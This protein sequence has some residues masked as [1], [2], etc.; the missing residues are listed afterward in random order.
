MLMVGH[1][2]EPLCLSRRDT[3]FIAAVPSHGAILALSLACHHLAL[4]INQCGAVAGA[5]CEGHD[6]DG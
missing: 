5:A 3:F 1:L 4:S 6:T 2:S